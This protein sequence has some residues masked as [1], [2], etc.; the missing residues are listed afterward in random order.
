MKKLCCAF[1]CMLLLIGTLPLAASQ[2]FAL[3]AGDWE[4]SVASGEATIVA[5][6]G[7][8]GEVVIPDTLGRVPVTR[9]GDCAFSGCTSLTKVTIPSGVVRIDA[10]AFSYCIAL[11]QLTIPAG[12][13]SVGAYA[14]CGCLA[15]ESVRIPVSVKYIG[16]LAFAQCTALTQVL[17]GGTAE[18][19]AAISIG[20]GNDILLDA[21][22]G[23][24]DSLRITG[25]R[26]DRTSAVVG[27]RISWTVTAKGGRGKLRYCFPVLKNGRVY[28]RGSYTYSRTGCFAPTSPGNYTVRVDVRDGRGTVVSRDSETI[29]FVPETPLAVGSIKADRQSARVGEKITWTAAAV[30]GSGSPRYC[31]YVLLDGT[32]VRKGSYGTSATFRYTPTEPGTY[33]VRVYIRD[34][35]GKTARR[36]GGKVIVSE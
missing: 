23:N 34:S 32:I 28:R 3:R 36:N 35:S 30:G 6:K 10:G 17:Y 8:G 7:A 26:V 21:Y 11:T 16:E 1:L 2:A 27:E 20:S 9:I 25:I 22:S 31:F 24:D 14:F 5:Y 33:S 19:W 15:L 13:A 12:T 18:Q 29:T 4:Y